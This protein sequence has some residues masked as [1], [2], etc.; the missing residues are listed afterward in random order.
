MSLVSASRT[1]FI[2]TY[3][4]QASFFSLGFPFS[5]NQIPLGAYILNYLESIEK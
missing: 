1:Y 2:E 4:I 5:R 3:F